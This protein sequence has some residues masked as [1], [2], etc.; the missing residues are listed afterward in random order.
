MDILV[1]IGQMLLA[2]TLLVG[3]HE[4]GHFITARM[5]GIRV[6]KFY[7]FFDAWG[8]KI[9]SKKIGDTE[10]GIGWLPLGG[11][12]KIAGMIDE[13]LDT[14]QMSQPAQDD[15]FR[16]KPAW[17]RLI[18]MLGGIIVNAVLAITIFMSIL[19]IWGKS[20][21]PVQSLNEGIYA[22]ELGLKSGLKNGDQLVAVNGVAL[23]E[24]NPIIS[25]ELIIEKN[26]QLSISRYGVPMTISFPDSIRQILM[27]R[28]ESLAEIPIPSI[29]H[30]IEKNMPAYA[31][32][33]REGDEITAMD[34][35][36]ISSYNEL[37]IQI[38]LSKGKIVPVT[39]LRNGQLLTFKV[40]L[41]SDPQF[42]I[43]AFPMDSIYQLKTEE[44]GFFASIPEAFKF[45]SETISN[46]IR[47][48][49]K[50]FSGEV[51]ARKSLGG[52]IA[53]AKDLYGGIWIWQKFWLTT[54]LLSLVLAFMNLLPIPAL[55]GGHALFTLF[56]IIFRRPL[57]TKFLTYAQYVG[58]V[59]V[60]G[61]M[62]F[63]LGNDIL[64]LFL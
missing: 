21:L 38:P 32:G 23:Q 26:A 3:L 2:L 41:T 57:S 61:L 47:S 19:M 14:N 36:P 60:L 63:I 45:A 54:A 62:V 7:I 12:V 13:S 48:F 53:I 8:G 40:D 31:A 11:Y 16:S 10:Y 37:F 22:T 15:E 34:G 51:S 9:W 59:I 4:W 27:E 49:Q 20:Y 29:I 52:P 5:F 64:K 35:K 58:M 43:R 56:E 50:I 46:Q 33:I 18:V 17:Q 44:F 25:P 6:E 1:M 39:A 30:K 24:F 28:K 55:D 42:G